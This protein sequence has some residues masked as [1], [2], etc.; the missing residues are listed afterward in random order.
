MRHLKLF[1]SHQ[2]PDVI[3][4]DI[5]DYGDIVG[6]VAGII[7]YDKRYLLNWA[8]EN[9]LSDEAAEHINNM[10]DAELLPAAILKNINIDEDKRNK[11]FGKMGFEDFLKH[12]KK[13]RTV[14]LIADVLEHN[15]FKLEDWYRKYGFSTIGYAGRSLPVMMKIQ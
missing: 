10:S 13:A 1:E 7:H 11:G 9:N 14:F 15:E 6:N 4:F 3:E 2:S 8:D 12:V 5:T